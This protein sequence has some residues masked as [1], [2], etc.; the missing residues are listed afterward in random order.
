MG[1]LAKSW[2]EKSLV[3]IRADADRDTVLHFNLGV[4]DLIQNGLGKHWVQLSLA[5][6][7]LI[8]IQLD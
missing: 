1:R 2:V 4:E 6:D 5:S 3:G 8:A 7:L